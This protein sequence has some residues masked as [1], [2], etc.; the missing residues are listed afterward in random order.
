[1]KPISFPKSAAIC[2]TTILLH[3][4]LSAQTEDYEQEP[5]VKLDAYTFSA[6]PVA[7]PVDDFVSPF[8]VMDGDAIRR[9]NAG[10]LG[11]LLDGQPG[12]T[13]SSFGGGASRPIIRGFD[14]PRVRIVESGLG[15]QDASETSPDHATTVEPLLTQ[16]VEVLRGPSTLLYGSS[17]IGGVVNVIGR[18]IPREQ[19][20]S[21]L[22]GAAEA[23]YDSA[24]EG[25]TYLGYGTFSE[26]PLVFTFQGLKR[27]SDDYEIP[28]KA[29]I[30]EEH[31]H[32]DDH[33]HDEEQ[34]HSGDTLD[35]SFVENQFYS[36]GASWF[37]NE[38]NYIGF[39]VSGY[40]ALY[41]VPGHEHAHEEED[42]DHDEAHEHGEEGVVI[43]MER[44]R[45]DTELAVF[46]PLQWIEALRVRFGYTDY[47]HQEL[48]D[49]GAAATFK[50]D[51]WELRA[52]ASH[53][54]WAIFDQGIFGMQVSDTDFEALGEEIESDDGFAFGPPSRT[55]SQ[56]VFISEHIHGEHVHFDVG[57]RLE[58]QT[59]DV[60]GGDYNDIATSLAF[61]AI[62]T[63]NERNSL[64]LSLQRT[65]RHPNAT[66]LYSNGPHLATSQFEVGD[67]DLG[68]ETAYGADIT[69]RHENDD[70]S[71]AASVFYTYFDNYIFAADSGMEEDGLSVF[72]YTEVEALFYG[73]ELELDYLLYQSADTRLSVGL[74]A[75]YVRARNEDD[76]NN[77]PRIPPFRLGGKAELAHGN[78]NAGL[79]LRHSF[80]QNDTAP[81]ETETDGFTELQAEIGYIFD[82]NSRS[83]ITF[84]ARANNLLDEEI[85]HHTSFLKDEAPRPGRNF[86]LGARYEFE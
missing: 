4:S 38:R 2:A 70:W 34:K 57:G 7:R 18:E 13:A 8:S 40:D 59:I 68:L 29:E 52:E 19:P 10:T 56:A 48:E 14:G 37:F 21:Q 65:E 53:Y 50:R 16:R 27:Q 85:R 61:G 47:Q 15:S 11:D 43:D 78:W 51:G 86:I 24:S 22:S 73:V 5:V 71:A 67:P 20:R 79:L 25:E 3:T 84:F 62:W 28:G 35:S 54:A 82:I 75:D 83:S 9:S 1:M 33:E 12:V 55:Q 17:A 26:G 81:T 76:N 80:D 36:I 60:S 49:G 45:F 74:L 30:H 42:H 77:L 31:E 64:T 23:R 63:I 72:N 58:R 39:A 32:D 46:D 66:E 69:F 44:T 41:G 6:G